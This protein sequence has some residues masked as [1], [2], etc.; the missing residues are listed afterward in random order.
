MRCAA[1]AGGAEG[2][3]V[4]LCLRERDHVIDRPGGNLRIDRHDQRQFRDQD[5]GRKILHRVIGQVGVDVR[6]DAVGCD[7]IQQQG[8]AVRVRFGDLRGGGGAAGAGAIADHDR[9]SQRV[10][11]LGADQPADEIGRAAGRNRDNELNRAVRIVLR[12][13]DVGLGKENSRDNE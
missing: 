1:A 11:K 5:D 12:A 8:V 6:A 4:R 10:G 13:R 9:L 2:E 7:R 3:L